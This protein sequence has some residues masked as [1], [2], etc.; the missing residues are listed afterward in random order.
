VELKNKIKSWRHRLE[1]DSQREFAK[2]LGVSHTQ[3]NR[4]EQQIVQPDLKTSWKIAVKI[5]NL[6][7]RKVYIEDLFESSE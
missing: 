2:L 1:I 4:W 7:E 5:S 6:I 3:V